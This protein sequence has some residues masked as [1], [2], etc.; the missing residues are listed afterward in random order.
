[1]GAVASR[2]CSRALWHVGRV[3]ERLVYNAPDRPESAG[4]VLP[5]A[6]EVGTGRY[7]GWSSRCCSSR[8]PAVQ[9]STS[10]S[11]R[12]AS[13]SAC[14]VHPA[15]GADAIAR[16]GLCGH[17]TVRVFRL[18]GVIPGWF[19]CGESSAAIRA[20]RRPRSSLWGCVLRSG[21]MPKPKIMD[22]DSR[23]C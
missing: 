10:T 7:C 13:Q 14:S 17:S 21:R 8:P 3:S 11:C 9:L 2:A 23:C 16:V 5:M 15:A 22:M 18:S 4:E 12:P 1:M 6:A 20:F 19:L